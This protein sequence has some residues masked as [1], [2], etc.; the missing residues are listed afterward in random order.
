MKILVPAI[1][2]LL[3]S[4]ICPAQ[5]PS[6]EVAGDWVFI[7]ETQGERFTRRAQL[8]LKDRKMEGKTGN[9]LIRGS[10]NG[11]AVELEWVRE[12]GQVEVTMTGK[13]ENGRLSGT[14][15]P[16]DGLI[17]TWSAERE[18]VRPAQP[19]T[20]EFSPT[21]FQRYF[22][23][24]LKPVLRINA[25]DTVK[26]WSVDAGGADQ[27][28]QRRSLGGNPLT[29][30]FYVEG[31]LP[32]DTLVVRLNRVRINRDWAQSGTGIVSNAVSPD[33]TANLKR[34][35]GFGG[36]WRLDA[37]NNTASLEK[38]G[39]ALKNF[40]VPVEPMVGCVAVAPR[41][42][43]VISTRDSG[44]FGGNMDY[45]RIREGTTVYLPVFHP[46]AILF[47]GDGHAAQGDGELTGD[48][49]ET[50]MEI[51]FTVDLI[52]GYSYGMPFAEDG[53]H[54][55]A[56]GIAGSLD[57]ALRRATTGMA[58]YLELEHGLNSNEAAVVMGFAVRYDVADL[59]G[60]QVSVV[61]KLPKTTLAQLPPRKQR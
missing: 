54:W 11:S 25:G 33:Y 48:A 39:D 12:S 59:V 14:A 20:H 9:N 55:M 29:G 3:S 41:G 31:A 49:L 45:N 53:E 21:E 44:G 27:Q 52:R 58:R 56:I 57:E 34:A 13:Y 19:R 46:G 5:N 30:P 37:K 8:S 7:L 43:E 24:S 2:L 18:S 61:A 22:S 51:E 50:S 42:Q 4:T 15:R 28:G 26:T 35:E 60:T 47:I 16:P 6:A 1:L 10:I 36:R 23:A 40:R 32:G 38:A 17:Y